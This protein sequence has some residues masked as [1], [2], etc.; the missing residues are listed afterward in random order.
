[1]SN[2]TTQLD[3]GILTIQPTIDPVASESKALRES[4]L[5]ELDAQSDFAK[6]QIDLQTVKILDSSGIGVLIATYNTLKSKGTPFSVI[7]ASSDIA[8][9]LNSMGLSN[10]FSIESA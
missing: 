5:A 9:L 3:D 10:H 6:V 8:A 7:N 2:I 4:I 1:M